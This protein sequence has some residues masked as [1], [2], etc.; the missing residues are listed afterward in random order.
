MKQKNMTVFAWAMAL[1]LLGFVFGCNSAV[2]SSSD[3]GTVALYLTDSPVDAETVKGVWITVTDIRYNLSMDETKD[4]WQSF[5]GFQGPQK[6]DLL[7]LSGGIVA[8]L[9]SMSLAAG[10]YNQIRFMLDAPES[11]QTNPVSPACYI[12]FTDGTTKPLFVPSGSDSGFKATGAFEV[13]INGTVAIVADFDVRKA[14]VRKGNGDYLLK[15][16]N[17]FRLIVGGEAGKIG[18]TVTNPPAGK[19]VVIYAYEND[20]Y[21]TAE[22]AEPESEAVRFPGAVT[23]AKVKKLEDGTYTYVIAFLA[24]E[25]DGTPAVY[26]LV[27]ASYASDGTFEGILTTRNSISDVSVSANAKTTLPIEF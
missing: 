11:N 2:T 12:E 10:Q 6:F 25:I 15:P 17:A 14:V 1:S 13:P 19:D 23:S 8:S 3:E 24:A 4:D 18:G 9:G 5:S 20:T 7:D 26:D 22:A 16:A 21:T 27:A